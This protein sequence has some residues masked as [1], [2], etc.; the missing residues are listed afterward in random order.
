MKLTIIFISFVILL[1]IAQVYVSK[2]NENIEQLEYKVIKKYGKFEVRKYEPAI[3]SS[4]KLG[5]KGYK[6]ASREGFGILAGYIFGSNESNETIAM[7]SPVT[8]ELGDT[9]KMLF[10]VPKTYKLESLPNPKN[11]KIIFEKHEEKMIAAI[12]FD[13]FA[14][15][16]KIEYYKSILIAELEKAKISHK[17]KFSF[18]GYNSPM[19]LTNRRNEVIVELIDYK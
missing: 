19:E 7:T 18:L 17:N 13:G 1:I 8:M 2:S 12:T 4:V 15:N 16:D 10:M 9:T 3:F 6:E 11:N 5:K 14:D